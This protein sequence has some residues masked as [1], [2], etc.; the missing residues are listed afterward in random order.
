MYIAEIR[1]VVERYDCRKEEIMK[2]PKPI[3]KLSLSKET[4]LQLSGL[5]LGKVAGGTSGWSCDSICPT[6]EPTDCRC[7]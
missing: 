3:H 4:L 5:D 1:K 7:V 2:K 6:V